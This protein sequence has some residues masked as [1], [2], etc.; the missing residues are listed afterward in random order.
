MNREQILIEAD[1]CVKCAICLPHCPTY[2]LSHDEGESPR[3]RIALIQAMTEQKLNSKRLHSHL[4]RCL[5]CLACEAAC[6]SGVRY[7]QLI[8]AARALPASKTRLLTR[9][10]RHLITRS[11]YRKWAVPLLLHYLKPGIRSLARRLAGRHWRRLDNL[12]PMSVTPLTAAARLPTG[13]KPLGRV[14]L[15]TGCAGRMVEGSALNAAV[16]VLTR[17]RF[18]VIIPQNQGCCGAMHQH[19]GDPAT[20]DR[21]TEVNRRAF[22]GLQVD[23]ILFLASGCGTQ[24]AAHPG[25]PQPFEAPVVE[26]SRFINQNGLNGMQLQPLAKSV[27]LHTPCTLKNRLQGERAP[28]QLLAR[29]PGLSLQPLDTS[30]GCC[31]AAGSYLLTQGEIADQLREKGLRPLTS[32]PPDYLATSNTGCA[33]HLAAGL[34]QAGLETRVVHPIELIDLQLPPLAGH[35]D[36]SG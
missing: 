33:I 17:S 2:R 29:I 23:A 6:P 32:A 14:A 24:L 4:D 15:F 9:L 12:L 18:E 11:S 3:G 25:G 5:G 8:D 31:G 21:M 28:E 16:R 19:G 1:R 20:A 7:G 26:L 13:D 34:R 35:R 36:Q 27:A 22:N 10:Q 30:E